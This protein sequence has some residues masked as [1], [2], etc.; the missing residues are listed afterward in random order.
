ML[1]L[2]LLINEESLKLIYESQLKR[3][4][5]TELVDFCAE[6]YK[7]WKKGKLLIKFT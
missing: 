2:L 6:L 1:D 4:K 3:F 7:Q 5:S